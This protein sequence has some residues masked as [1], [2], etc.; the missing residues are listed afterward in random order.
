MLEPRMRSKRA[1]RILVLCPAPPGSRAGNRV[2]A[3]RWRR[4]LRELGH[5]V[6]IAETL[7][8]AGCDVLVALH[9]RRSSQAIARFR[10]ERPEAPLVVAL[11]GTDLYLDLP[12]SP[13]ARRSVRLATRLVVLQ[14]AALDEL[15]REVHAKVRVILQSAVA[16]SGARRRERSFDVAVVGHL[17]P[18]KDPFRAEEAARGLPAASR[19]RIVHAGSAL[20]PGLGPEAAAR[21]RANPRYRY[22]GELPGWRAR[23]LI[24]SSR[25]LVLTSLAEGGANVISEAVVA[26]TPVLA[27]RIPSSEGLLGR[28]YPG[29]FP[30]RD[31]GALRDLLLRAE[32]DAP[33]LE[34]LADW[35]RRLAPRFTPAR[36]KAAWAK[37]LGE[38][39]QR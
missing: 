26:G 10:R 23:R 38:L 18:V 21:A 24:A 34:R 35:C 39:L 6:E 16:P 22:V 30:P 8:P 36:E 14:P 25:L 32:R 15:P 1:L 4:V 5:R 20:E 37:L 7:S 28:R 12:T 27:S 2:T 29:F 19:L 9:A 3:L 13:E 31:T 33:F 17:R 11:T